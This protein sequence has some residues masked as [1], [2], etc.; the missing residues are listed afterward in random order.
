MIRKQIGFVKK[1]TICRYT[2]TQKYY[3]LVEV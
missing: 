3:F 2:F 1:Q